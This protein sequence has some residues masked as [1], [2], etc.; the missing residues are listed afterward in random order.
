MSEDGKNPVNPEGVQH[1]IDSQTPPLAGVEHPTMDTTIEENEFEVT[2]EDIPVVDE[3]EDVKEFGDEVAEL[4]EV[5]ED[6]KEEVERTIH[7]SIPCSS[8]EKLLEVAS[9]DDNIRKED[10][11]VKATTTNKIFKTADGPTIDKAAQVVTTEVLA[12]SD[13]F[14]ENPIR[15]NK[16][17]KC[18]QNVSGRQAAIAFAVR[19]KGVY[20]LRLYNSGFYILI[21]PVAAERLNAI[22]ET[23][24]MNGEI[25]GRVIGEYQHLVYD[26]LFKEAIMNV[27][28]E[29]VIGSNLKGF[30]RGNTLVKSIAFNDYD[31]IV[32]AISAML[33]DRKLSVGVECFEEECMNSFDVDYDFGKFH[34]VRDIPADAMEFIAAE[35]DNIDRNAL[36]EY[37]E[38]LGNTES[39]DHQGIR[40]EL[41]EPSLHK[42]VTNAKD[43][44]AKIE[45]TIID[46]P[47]ISNK[48][49]INELL[50]GYNDNFTP[51][52][53]SLSQIGEDGK[54]EFRTTDSKEY[55]NILSICGLGIEHA[56]LT[57]SIEEFIY[58]SRVSVIG[59]IPTACPKCKSEQPNTNGYIAWD[60][61]RI[62]FEI[63][64]RT[65]D[66]EGISLTE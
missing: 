7:M 12:K 17:W 39:A 15:K 20:K 6:E 34:L 41:T 9:V 53:S 29:L 19:N 56:D 48:K 51:W 28:P 26:V 43:I 58:K 24:D 21:C 40:I 65:L 37:K 50:L 2:V 11:Y 59:Y 22:F 14:K 55:A 54:V 42:W 47:T 13:T 63:A 64:Y 10:V 32:W 23:I 61:E 4:E 31:P 57:T 8:I 25:L 33:V 1:P 45:S 5:V 27:L 36:Q 46:E 44:L 16:K 30:E 38:L 35:K 66:Q 60:P 49:V 52:I 62:F 3:P 18:S